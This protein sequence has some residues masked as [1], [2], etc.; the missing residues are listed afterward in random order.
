MVAGLGVILLTY[1]VF[2]E[3]ERRQ[4]AVFLIGAGCLLV[5]ALSIGNLIFTIAMAGLF[6]AALIEFVEILLGIRKC[7]NC[8][9]KQDCDLR[10][11]INKKN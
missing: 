2:L 1:G 9:A 10:K 7:K 5:Y 11:I 8:E 4:D 6:L 3:T